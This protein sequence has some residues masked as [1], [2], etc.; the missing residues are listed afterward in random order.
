MSVNETIYLSEQFCRISNKIAKS[1]LLIFRVEHKAHPL[2]RKQQ[3]EKRDLFNA[4]QLRPRNGLL[5]IPSDRVDCLISY[6]DWSKADLREPNYER[7]HQNS[8]PTNRINDLRV[9]ANRTSRC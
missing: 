7:V 1:H 9:P 6:I 3:V 2:A 5:S 4:H 8:P